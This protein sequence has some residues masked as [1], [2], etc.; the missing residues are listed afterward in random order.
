MLSPLSFIA[1]I[2][3]VISLKCLCTN[4]D[5]CV[6]ILCVCLIKMQ[7]IAHGSKRHCT[8]HFLFKTVHLY[9]FIARM[10][11]KNSQM[12]NSLLM[13]I[14]RDHIISSIENRLTINTCFFY[15]VSFIYYHFPLS[16]LFR[17]DCLVVV[18]FFS[19]IRLKLI[20]SL[21]NLNHSRLCIG[22]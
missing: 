4:N 12:R 8:H 14:Q 17:T 20:H 6:F 7:F 15:P 11:A 10:G 19:F 3:S 5:G 9:D 13:T 1:E 22:L 2:Q 18:V 21:G 16:T